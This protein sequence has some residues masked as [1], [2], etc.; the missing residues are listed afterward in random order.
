MKILSTLL[1]FFLGTSSFFAQTVG[2][3]E[4]AEVS[5]LT[6]GP[7]S[8]LY[9]KFGHSA[10][11]VK[12][13]SQDIDLVYNYGVYDFDT[14]NFYTKFAQGKLLYKLGVSYYDSFFQSYKAQNRWIKAQ[15]LDLTLSEKQALFDFLQNNA[16]PENRYY[17]YDFFYDN[18]ATKIRDVLVAVLGEKLTYTSDYGDDVYTFRE[19]IQKNVYWNSWGSLGMDVAIGAVVDRPATAWEYQF[20]PEY[21]FESA[22]TARI[23]SNNQPLDL[24]SKTIPLFENSPTEERTSYFSS[25][26]FIFSILGSII[27][28]ITFRDFK[29]QQRS[30][31]LDS[32][33]Y[34]ITGLVGI[35]LILLWTATDHSSTVNNYNLLWAFPINI[36]LVAAISSSNPKTWLSRYVFFQMLLLVLLTIHWISGVQVFAMGLLPLLLALLIRHLYVWHSLKKIATSIAPDKK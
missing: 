26:F 30:G 24:V 23:S 36:L 18:C 29:R 14:P 17:K 15:V 1:L 20:L 10:Y 31:G 16:K 25:P 33:L 2:L 9:D 35:F 12:D 21:V 6:I 32:F 5:I 28:F 4:T 7:G 3:S 8:Q 19:L 13:E 27:L 34:L 22:A 11:R